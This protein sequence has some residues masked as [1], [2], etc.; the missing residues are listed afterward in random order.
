MWTCSKITIPMHSPSGFLSQ[1]SQDMNS[2]GK[3]L[4]CGGLCTLHTEILLRY[5]KACTAIKLFYLFF[6]PPIRIS[7]GPGSIISLI[8]L[9]VLLYWTWNKSKYLQHQLIKPKISQTAQVVKN[10]Q[11]FSGLK[12]SF[13]PLLGVK[14]LSWVSKEITLSFRESPYRNYFSWKCSPCSKT[15]QHRIGQVGWGWANC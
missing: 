10:P 1:Q 7:W 4:Y 11:P 13:L 5:F 9:W 15:S 12:H 6:S 8:K 2:V 14:F 3:R